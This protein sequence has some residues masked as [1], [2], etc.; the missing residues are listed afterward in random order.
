MAAHARLHILQRY[1]WDLLAQRLDLLWQ[2]TAAAAPHPTAS[3]ATPGPS[4]PPAPADL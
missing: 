2:Q 3:L 1:S 4:V